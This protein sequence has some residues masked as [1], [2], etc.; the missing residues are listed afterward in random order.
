EMKEIKEVVD[1][2]S[3]KAKPWLHP[4]DIA[5]AR[6][7][8]L[9]SWLLRRLASLP[10]AFL[11][12]VVLWV[13]GN[14]YIIPFVVPLIVLV[15]AALAAELEA[16]QAWGYIPGKRMDTQRDS[17]ALAQVMNSFI[18]ALALVSGLLILIGWVSTHD[19]TEGVEEVTIGIGA[20]IAVIQ[21]AEV[22]A[23]LLR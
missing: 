17:G 12:G 11:F 22:I 18:E 9:I 2:P 20:G 4:L 15:T 16:G 7:P 6:R 3:V 13:I 14:N 1:L 23:A 19:F 21:V 10:V 8:Y 5:P